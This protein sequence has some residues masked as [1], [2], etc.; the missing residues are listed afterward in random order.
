MKLE[1][2]Y[3]IVAWEEAA[4]LYMANLALEIVNPV[5]TRRI[6]VIEI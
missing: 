6:D 1:T 5:N 3:A 2:T 4:S